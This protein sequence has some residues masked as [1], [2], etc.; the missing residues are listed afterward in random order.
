MNIYATQDDIVTK[1]QSTFTAMSLPFTCVHIP[2]TAEGFAVL[3]AWAYKG[4]NVNISD[5][6]E[7][8]SETD[9]Y[10]IV[11]VVNTRNFAAAP[12]D[13]ETIVQKRKLQFILELH[14]NTLYGDNGLYVL[15]DWIEKIVTGFAPSN[16]DKLY[17]IKDELLQTK[18][19]LWIHLFVFEC[20]T[21]LVQEDESDPIIVPSLTTVTEI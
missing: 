1:V 11:Y 4:T 8:Y 13:T 17:L 12:E 14:G 7:D 16:C 10:P 6:D 3:S 20:T 2:D 5:T 15:R 9:T 19:K 18:N 21:L